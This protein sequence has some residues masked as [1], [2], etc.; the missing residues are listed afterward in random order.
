MH[1]AMYIQQFNQNMINDCCGFV[2]GDFREKNCDIF[3]AIE[4]KFQ[5]SVEIN[6]ACPP[7]LCKPDPL[8]QSM[9]RL[10]PRNENFVKIKI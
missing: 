1:V 6:A 3:L 8:A 10:H 4:K 5:Q 2:F 7:H 9:T